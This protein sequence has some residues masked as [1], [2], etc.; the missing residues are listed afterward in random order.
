MAVGDMDNDKHLD[1]ITVNSQQD[2]FMIHYYDA[3]KYEY[4]SDGKWVNI[5]LDKIKSITQKTNV[6][7]VK[8]TNIVVSKDVRPRQSL[9]I[10]MRL[11]YDSKIESEKETRIFV[12][13]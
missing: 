4:N 7:D 2:Q 3:T 8:I 9:Y 11:N 6:N 12:Y 5:D 10:V 1:L 13:K